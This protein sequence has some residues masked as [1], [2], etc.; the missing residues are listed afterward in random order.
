MFRANFNTVI[1]L[2]ISKYTTVTWGR[3]KTVLAKEIE[4][5][6]RIMKRSVNVFLYTFET[7]CVY[8]G[9]IVELPRV[10]STTGQSYPH[11]VYDGMIKDHQYDTI[12]NLVVVTQNLTDS[13]KPGLIG[14]FR[15]LKT[16]QPNLRLEIVNVSKNDTNLL[17]QHMGYYAEDLVFYNEWSKNIDF[18]G[19]TIQG[20]IV[21]FIEELLQM[22]DYETEMVWTTDM[23]ATTLN[24][25]G[26]LLSVLYI[27]YPH[28]NALIERIKQSF[29]RLC[30]SDTCDEILRKSFMIKSYRNFEE[31]KSDVEY[32]TETVIAMET[33]KK[34][35]TV[36]GALISISLPL[37]TDDTTIHTC[38]DP[39]IIKYNY[40]GYPNSCD[41][42]GNVYFGIDDRP[43]SITRQA[44]ND[45][46]NKPSIFH[47]ANIMS[48]C[49]VRKKK[50]DTIVEQLRYLALCQAN[51]STLIAKDKYD[52]QSCYHHWKKGRLIPMSYDND[53]THT[54][55]FSD[56]N[57][58]YFKLPESLW[59]AL[60]MS[61]LGIFDKQ[62]VNYST[63]LEAYG[64]EPNEESLM[65]YVYEG[66]D[67]RWSLYGAFDYL[68]WD[69]EIWLISIYKEENDS[70]GVDN[71]I[72][73]YVHEKFPNYFI[74]NGCTDLT[75]N[76]WNSSSLYIIRG[77]AVEQ[78]KV[79]KHILKHDEI[80]LLDIIHT[81]KMIKGKSYA[82]FELSNLG[83][84]EIMLIEKCIDCKRIIGI[85]S[86]CLSCGF[87][88][89]LVMLVSPKDVIDGHVVQ[90]L[91]N[92]HTDNNLIYHTTII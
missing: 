32:E 89:D 64:I 22:I 2:D 42:Y 44:I 57:V 62:L 54:S 67:L 50:C 58:N 19:K 83:D 56:D 88:N 17:S 51:E 14:Q 87:E 75:M 86:G 55:L 65:S 24:E 45:I 81:E 72:E 16:K 73:N 25:L 9:R 92:E 31:H 4:Y 5:V 53:K 90:Y 18:L 7:D 6:N 33:L 79:Y 3:S 20:D 29:H 69:E 70:G 47:V 23:I 48:V 41:K 78:N 84:V 74:E 15:L 34:H 37:S 61:M 10:K 30:D 26:I 38:N 12:D 76:A 49:C 46:L 77:P 52:K 28:N 68:S 39:Y 8:H 60:M 85:P 91:L 27:M 82:F 43:H 80:S 40:N 11:K 71:S 13:D 66:S 21:C 36:N 1:A 63:A 59:W 35:G